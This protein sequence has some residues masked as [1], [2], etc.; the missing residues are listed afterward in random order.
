M[1][2]ATDLHSEYQRRK[3]ATRIVQRLLLNPLGTVES[4]YVRLFNV[5]EMTLVLGTLDSFVGFA[6]CVAVLCL[7]HATWSVAPNPTAGRGRSAPRV[8]VAGYAHGVPMT[9]VSLTLLMYSVMVG[10]F[11]A[12]G[13]VFAPED[14]TVG[15]GIGVACLVLSGTTLLMGEVLAR[16][17]VFI[18]AMCCSSSPREPTRHRHRLGRSSRSDLT[19]PILHD[20]VRREPQTTTIE[21]RADSGLSRVSEGPPA[22]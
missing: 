8:V 10:L 19:L 5:M 15:V 16:R 18:F 13:D 20:E 9:A 11:L 22:S 12:G 14:W 2:K 3:P 21:S 7:W 6:G 4:G 17:G 1:R